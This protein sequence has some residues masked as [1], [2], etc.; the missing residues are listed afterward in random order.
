[1]RSL[2]RSFSLSLSPPLPLSPPLSP[3]LSLYL[4]L[5]HKNINVPLILNVQ[6]I[7][8]LS[9]EKHILGHFL[10][11]FGGPQSFWPQNA[12]LYVLPTKKKNNL[13][14]FQNQWY[15]NSYNCIEEKSKQLC[16][17]TFDS[18][19]QRAMLFLWH[20]VPIL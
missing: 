3:P 8:F 18:P 20:F 10:E 16:Y 13:P 7:I 2:S 6:E 4:S 11:F 12:P 5:G 1:L 19:R 9:G 17:E 14:D 15:I